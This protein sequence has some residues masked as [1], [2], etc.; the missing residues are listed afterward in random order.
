MPRQQDEYWTE[1]SWHAVTKPSCWS[2][3]W[4][5]LKTYHCR[6]GRTPQPKGPN[7]TSAEVA[8]TEGIC[9]RRRELAESVHDINRDWQFRR[10]LLNHSS[11]PTWWRRPQIGRSSVRL[12]WHIDQKDGWGLGLEDL[13]DTPAHGPQPLYTTRVPSRPKYLQRL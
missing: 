7:R 9:R 11:F 6:L 5:A 12:T 8:E 10:T 4:T 2:F 1:S 3:S 13:I